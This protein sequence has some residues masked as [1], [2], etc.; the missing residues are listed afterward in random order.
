M[1]AY[2]IF[3]IEAFLVAVAFAVSFLFPRSWSAWRRIDRIFVAWSHWQRGYAFASVGVATL[4]LHIAAFPFLTT[5]LP[6]V[7]DEFSYLL[8]AQTFLEGRPANPPYP[9]WKSLESPHVIFTP[10]YASMYPP[11]QGL[12]LAFGR[13]VGGDFLVGPMISGAI[14]ASLSAWMLA[15]WVPPRWALLGG[16]LAG[17]R[18]GLF[19]YWANSYWGGSGPAIGGM[20]VVGALPRFL[21]NKR[22][23]DAVLVALGF[24]VLG[25]SRPFETVLMIPTCVAA[26]FAV[27]FRPSAAMKYGISAAAL[28]LLAA[29]AALLWYNQAT[30]GNPLETGYHLALQRYGLAVLPWHSTASVELPAS[31]SLQR[32]YNQQHAYFL[33]HQT[34]EGFALTRIVAFIRFWV[35]FIGPLLTVPFFAVCLLFCS[36]RRR[37]IVIAGLVYV[38]GLAINPWFFPHYF[39]PATGLL[40]LALIQAIRILQAQRCVIG[41]RAIPVIASF[42]VLVRLSAPALGLP[43]PQDRFSMSWF[44]T[45]QGNHTRAAVNARL[46]REAGLHL[47]LVSYAGEHDPTVEWVYN[48]PSLDQSKVVWAHDLDIALNEKLLGYFAGRRVWTARVRNDHVEIQEGQLSR[49]K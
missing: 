29:A 30:T 7:H 33:N 4:V 15:G 48:G 14:I 47:V 10:R 25:A 24:A 16:L 46:E 37:W 35:F 34:F 19:T 44:H 22:V 6:D 13:I 39:A 49:R 5:R 20:L 3:F 18:L 11:V 45:P 41:M 12:I 36:R 21:R 43:L 28:I 40:L 42:M 23:R 17:I 31:A 1:G 26:C 27:Q 2:S 9:V 38:A 32:F 8:S